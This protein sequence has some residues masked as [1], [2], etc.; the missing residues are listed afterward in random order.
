MEREGEARKAVEELKEYYD[1]LLRIYHLGEGVR[2]EEV[3]V[4]VVLERGKVKKEREERV[5]KRR[6]R[7]TKQR[8]IK[9][10]NEN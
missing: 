6:K 8:E 7:D 9:R 1:G 10:Q 4:K 3:K 2:E 5:M